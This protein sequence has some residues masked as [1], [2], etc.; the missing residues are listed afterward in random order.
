[1]SVRAILQSVQ[2]HEWV[3]HTDNKDQVLSV[4]LS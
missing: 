4:N 3:R 1:M 2:Y